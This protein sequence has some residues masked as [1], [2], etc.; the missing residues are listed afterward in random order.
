MWDSALHLDCWAVDNFS[1]QYH[2]GSMNIIVDALS[3]I[4]EVNMLSFMERKSDLLDY[5]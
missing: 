1:I 4:K 2:K 3:R 5:L